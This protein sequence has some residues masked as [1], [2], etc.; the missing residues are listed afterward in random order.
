[1]PP[2]ERQIRRDLVGQWVHKA[3][4]DLK[5]AEILFRR[6]PPLLYP[7]CFHSQQAGEKY[8]KAF[9]TH[10]QID[11]P[12]THVIGELLVQVGVDRV[13]LP[14]VTTT[15]GRHCELAACCSDVG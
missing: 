2:T 5:A 15:S 9:L 11:F 1:M 6:K 3:E 12:K 4:Q 7:S 8:L 13:H 10:N 14:G